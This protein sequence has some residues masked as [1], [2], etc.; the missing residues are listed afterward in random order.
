MIKLTYTK[1]KVIEQFLVHK[2]CNEIKK[3]M[4]YGKEIY[5]FYSTEFF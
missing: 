3:N 5:N 2:P 4:L 1:F